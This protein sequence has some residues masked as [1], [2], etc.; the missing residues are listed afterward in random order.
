MRTRFTIGTAVGFVVA[1]IALIVNP[2]L[3]QEETLNNDPYISPKSVATYSAPFLK[4]SG[5]RLQK[6]GKERVVL[7]GTV[8]LNGS[9]PVPIQVA[10]EFPQKIRIDK[11]TDTVVFDR[12]D[13]SREIP[14]NAEMADAIETLLEDSVE[15]FFANHLE[16]STRFLGSGFRLRDGGPDAPSYD[17]VVV[18]NRSRVRG[19]Q[20]PI[21][22]QYWFDKR[23]K[24]LSRVVYRR[25][26]GSVEVFWSD[27]RDVQGERIPFTVE[28]KEL[29][30]TTLLVKLF[31]ASVSPKAE[32]GYFS[33][34]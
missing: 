26:S 1:G 20:E 12:G 3:A 33:G 21:V 29:G 17:I 28:R 9:T 27:W 19:G 23:M 13:P 5:E 11:G 8:S 30:R 7:A 25:P 34:R 22:K 24:L 10:W 2:V 4:A 18:W 6:P 32:D 15:G 31:A 16:G 14:S